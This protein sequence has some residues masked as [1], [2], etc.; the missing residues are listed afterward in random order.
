MIVMESRRWRRGGGVGEVLSLGAKKA[1]FGGKD[2]LWKWRKTLHVSDILDGAMNSYLPSDR[3]SFSSRAA[4]RKEVVCCWLLRFFCWM[5]SK[6][7]GRV[8]FP[9]ALRRARSLHAS[10]GSSLTSLRLQT[11]PGHSLHQRRTFKALFFP[12][13]LKCQAQH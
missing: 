12:P 11:L 7:K 6:S 4:G 13:F 3:M 2:F 8:D 1:M 5:T 9:L 10:A